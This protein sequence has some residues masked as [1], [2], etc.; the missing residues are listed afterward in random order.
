[1]GLTILHWNA[2]SLIANGA[3]LKYFI[4]DQD[5]KP[6]II[7][8][9]ETWLRPS[10]DFVIYGYTAIRKD[11][12]MGAGGGVA[13]FIQQ[14]L[15]YRILSL[16]KEME[17][18]VT[19]I[20]VDNINFVVVNLYN[21]CQK[22]TR[23][24][25]ESVPVNWNS[26]IIFC[27]DFNAHNTLWGSIKTDDNGDIL[28]EFMDDFKL[29]CLNDGR[30]TRFDT[31]H[32]TESAIDLSILSERIAGSSQWDVLNKH[33]LGSDHYPVFVK[34]NQFDV[35]LE[36]NWCPRWKM[37]EANWALF[38]MKASARL[39]GNFSYETDDIEE[40]NTIITGILYET[41]EETIGKSTGVREKRMVPWWTTE[42][43]ETIKI[44]NKAF[45]K[46]KSNHCYDNLI[47]YKRAQ[48]V[49][50]R[51]VRE[52][53]KR[54]WRDFCSTIGAETK[55]S[56]VW[57]MIRKM[58][59]VRRDFSLPVLKD[60]SG[61]AVSNAEKAEMLARAFV[62]VHSSQ[63]LSQ[64][65]VEWRMKMIVDNADI[66]DKKEVSDSVMDK[67]FTLFELNRALVGARNTSPGKDGICYRMIDVLSD[68]AKYEI[69]KLYNRVWES[70]RLP[71][72]WKHST[73]VPVAKPGK[74]KADVRSYRPIALT[75]NLCKLMERMITKRLVYDLERRGLLTPH[76]SGFRCNRTTM[77]PIVCLENE[78]RKAQVN[79][80][81][82]LAVLFDIEKAYDMLWKEGLLLKLHKMGI[83]GK[84]FNWVRDFLKGRTIEV[85]VGLA[86]SNTYSIQNG[87]PQGSVC[88]PILF[89]IMINDVFD[90]V[91]A[92]LSKALYADDGALW[93]RGKNTHILQDRMQTAIGQ[94]ERWSHEWGFHLSV[95]KTQVICFSKKTVNPSVNLTLYGQLLKQVDSVRY[96]GVWFDVK[97][98]FKAHIRKTVDKCK[99]S[100]NVLKCVAGNEWGASRT[101]L[102][103][104]YTA[105]IRPAIDY[106]CIVYS[107]AAKT[108]LLELDRIQASAMRICCGAFRTSS[109]PALQVETGE[110]PLDLRRLQISSTYWSKL[111]GSA[112]SHPT[113]QILTACWEYGKSMR[114]FG[115]ESKL[116]ASLVKDC[117]V[118]L[119]NTDMGSTI[120]P[121]LFCFPTVNMQA[122]NI[123]K[124]RAVYQNV[125]QFIDGMYGH[126]TQIYTDASRTEN[127]RTGAA[128]Y[129]PLFDVAVKKRTS[130][131]LSIYTAEMLAILMAL[132]WIEEVKP[133]DVVI[134]SDSMS[135]LTSI[136]SGN[137]TCRQDLLNK[138]HQFVF[139]LTQQN[140][141]V[142]FLWVPA[143]KGVEGNEKADYLA[144][145]AI[146]ADAVELEVPLN[147]SEL[148]TV[149]KENV[150]KLWQERWDTDKKGRH[151]YQLQKSVGPRWGGDQTRREQVLISRLR[152]GHTALNSGLFTIGKHQTGTCLYC[153]EREG[154]EHVLLHC[155]QYNE[156]REKLRRTVKTPLTLQSL[157]SAPQVSAIVRFLSE[158]GLA[159]RI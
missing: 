36:E 94:V 146:K 134:C 65:E 98:S 23:E 91:D 83:H 113:K 9:Q 22:I 97:L 85:R 99:R 101:S 116:H 40:A 15:N 153:N 96:L 107:S 71:S 132:Q 53:K 78:I 70:G 88:S 110:M 76:Q 152:I 30:G 145:E 13:T 144:K 154:V 12:E 38:S 136:L 102:I 86:H 81:T 111:Q 31:A 82:V 47:V 123:L 41:A 44:R 17:V 109:I 2:R 131:F 79:K 125:Q 52:A 24:M 158:T 138:I 105:L 46:L 8:V 33:P 149:I 25:L 121:W 137:S 26:R 156:E 3:E 143:H 18:I 45:R 92:R 106:G 140:L 103:R 95:E 63:N 87:T 90:Y 60:S 157:L 124:S 155:S 29:V 1:M 19:E 37:R 64:E 77:D 21:P 141:F 59:G 27:G 75:S 4:D 128:F 68:M 126:A 135:S 147:N 67:D 5:V 72:C 133:R 159:E 66:L 89:N 50:K 54:Y 14:G 117:N 142:Q 62:K 7:C 80:E 93:V 148:R 28:E 20:W 56:E 69:L 42:C 129:V 43:K 84:M 55:V 151:L 48:A 120:P 49:V 10:L 122:K 112:D 35:R 114:S 11:R 57:G 127:G 58:G 130:D 100:V 6:N 51:T 74:D 139:L 39:L 115:W 61:E 104:I 32:G 34:I 150:N 108:T 118:T 16:H 119:C 73:I